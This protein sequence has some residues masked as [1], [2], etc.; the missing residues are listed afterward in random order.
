MLEP[1]GLDAIVDRD[2]HRHGQGHGLG[3]DEQPAQAARPQP[4]PP[5]SGAGR[6]DVAICVMVSHF[7]IG[8]GRLQ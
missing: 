2:H 4:W 6:D 8:G 3:E 5:R 1:A 7:L